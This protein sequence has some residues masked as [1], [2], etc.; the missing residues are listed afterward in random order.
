[1]PTFLKSVVIDAPVEAV[2]SFH[3]RPDALRLLSPAFPP[4]RVIRKTGGLEP[5]SRVELRIGPFHWIA[6]HTA[7]EKNCFF[8][9]RQVSGPFTEWIHRH[10]FEAVGNATRLTDRIQYRLPGGTWTNRLFGWVLEVGLQQMF[11]YRHQVTKRYCGE[12]PID[13]VSPQGS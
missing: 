2:F 12:V 13:P 3:E 7:Y 10:E 1:M 5:G 11:H 4:V 9:D 8:E 6:L